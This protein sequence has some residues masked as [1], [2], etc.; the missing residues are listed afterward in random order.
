[1]MNKQIVTIN[2]II[3][4]VLIILFI[5]L[6]QKRRH[7]HK[8]AE[9]GV[10]IIDIFIGIFII[11]LCALIPSFLF[12][13]FGYRK[14]FVYISPFFY[15]MTFIYIIYILFIKYKNNIKVVIF[16]NTMD[17][18]KFLWFIKLF[19]LIIIFNTLIPGLLIKSRGLEYYIHKVFL[20]KT[21]FR[22]L[23][24]THLNYPHFIL[25]MILLGVIISPIIEELLYR[26]MLYGYLKKLFDLKTAFVLALTLFYLLH[27]SISNITVIFWGC[28]Y[29]WIYEKTTAVFYCILAHIA[30]NISL[31]IDYFLWM[32]KN[33]YHCENILIFIGLFA[34]IVF[35]SIIILQRKHSNY[36]RGN[37][38][39]IQ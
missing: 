11:N 21:W 24:Y 30:K 2:F 15:I 12:N 23:K 37:L 33:N 16:E 35:V 8:N 25:P 14:S 7:A 5:F 20:Y 17:L 6:R 32:K 3:L 34:I 27:Y 39:Y 31:V 18:S 26:K 4:Q 22:P 38:G 9:Q 29:L 13:C 36:R 1:M 19:S 28:I 10:S